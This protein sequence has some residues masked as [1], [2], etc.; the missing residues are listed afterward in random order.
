MCHSMLTTTILFAVAYCG[1]K[2]AG[3]P[4]SAA[5][6]LCKQLLYAPHWCNELLI[7]TNSFDGHCGTVARWLL[8]RITMT[9]PKDL[10][11]V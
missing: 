7:T 11:T 6:V 3:Q 1:A 9:V 2:F 4:V 8:K 10:V 5:A